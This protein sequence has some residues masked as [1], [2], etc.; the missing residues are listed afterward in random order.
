[1]ACPVRGHII[2]PS[3]WVEMSVR[4][5]QLPPGSVG[6]DL[7]PSL[8]QALT[9]YIQ[10]PSQAVVPALHYVTICGLNNI[11]EFLIAERSRDVNAL[12][13]NRNETPLTM[14]SRIRD[15]YG[16]QRWKTVRRHRGTTRR[17]P[18]AHSQ[19]SQQR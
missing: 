17:P 14:A 5:E 8:A 4:P 18:T 2:I 11:V 13:F 1:M 19:L 7:R 15:V 16:A 3:R 9:Q 10:V 12:G 6:L